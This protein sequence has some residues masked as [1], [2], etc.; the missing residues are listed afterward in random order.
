MTQSKSP[1]GS[2][3]HNQPSG[4]ALGASLNQYTANDFLPANR[5]GLTSGLSR[6]S[7]SYWQDA[8][9]RLRK[10]KQSLASLF[11]VSSLLIF[12]FLGP[13]VWT[14][15]PNHQDQTQISIGLSMGAT[16]IVI[17]D[18]NDWP[19][20]DASPIPA[21]EESTQELGAPANL[22]TVD[23]VSTL[24]VRL[25]WDP[26]PGAAA[27]AIYRNEIAPEP[28]RLGVPL[29]ST[30]APERVSYEDN[31]SL[32]TRRYYYS[33]VAIN[34][35]GVESTSAST[36]DLDLKPGMS[37]D[38]AQETKADAKEGD[39]IALRAAPLGTDSLGRDLLA[40][41]M[42]GGKIS[43]FIGLFAAFLETLIGAMIGGI[44][45]FFGGRIDNYIMRVTDFV[46]GL[47]FLLFVILLKVAMGIGPG[48]SGITALI[49]ALV[50]LSWP[51]AAR[52]V[53]GQ[54]LQ[55]RESEFIHAARMMGARPSYLLMRH[56]FPNLLG[57]LLVSLTFNIPSAIFAEAFLSFIGLGVAAPAA[58]WG[59]LCND[60]I[61]NILTH[62][63]E[64]L[65]PAITI[66]L[67]VLAFN[68]LGDGL[69]DAL[70]P[71]MRANE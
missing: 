18:R 40:R 49:I 48:E 57:I 5:A 28:D 52:L 55:M 2:L 37:L 53:R 26:V 70:D 9:R 69:R 39:I 25:A 3:P 19:G 58:S 23:V 30:Q 1:P 43:I 46:L 22:R 66:S 14:V 17:G 60:S 41:L 38:L 6:P 59:S 61:Q 8:W 15:D 36:L 64:F 32:Q 65:A 29:G 31:E 62:P 33:V 45:G 27:Y 34:A 7:L 71:K 11:V 67:T 12:V 35:A 21:I 63:H 4:A 24:G 13:L 54:V 42:F 44:S 47:P 50:V 56:M 51:G 68:L 10:N 16:A 20:L